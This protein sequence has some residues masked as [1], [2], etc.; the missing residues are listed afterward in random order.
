MLGFAKK[1]AYNW[2]VVSLQVASTLRLGGLS[3]W[4]SVFGIW[5]FSFWDLGVQ[6]LGFGGSVFGSCREKVFCLAH[7]DDP[8]FW[9][10]PTTL[11]FGSCRLPHKTYGLFIGL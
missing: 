10:M 4:G 3:F 2:A 5:G 7:A 1:T 11:Y 9:F 6:F 8:L